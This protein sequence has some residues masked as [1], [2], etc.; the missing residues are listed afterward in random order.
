MN[1]IHQLNHRKKKKIKIGRIQYI[2]VD[3][4]YYDFD[5]KPL[6][7]EIQMISRPPAI[8]NKMMAEDTLDLSSVSLSAFARNSDQ[9]LILPDLSISCYGKV[10]SVLLVSDHRFEELDGKKILLTDESATAV[11]LLKLLFSLNGIHPVFQTGKIK[12]PAD[13]TGFAW[14]GLVIGDA[15]LKHK[16]Q[17][18]FTHVLDLCEMW[19]NMTGLPF[20]FGIWAV[21][22][23]FAQKY[24]GTI[25][26]VLE[27][28]KKSKQNGLNNI[29]MISRLSAKKLGIDDKLCKTYFKSMNYS[30]GDQEFKCL[31]EFFNG[32]YAEKIIEQQPDISFFNNKVR[33]PPANRA[34]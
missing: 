18:H 32:L 24:P 27:M 1:N 31:K 13:L 26:L 16:W 7:P 8:L 2:N 4:V 23:S 17:N 33:Q 25:S 15:A 9:W 11:D 14:A 5:N 6:P 28:L 20:V 21:R 10:M 29:S 12:S 3:P 34:V 22:K 30:F 19:N